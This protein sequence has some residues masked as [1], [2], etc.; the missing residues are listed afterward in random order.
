MPLLADG[1]THSFIG[2]WVSAMLFQGYSPKTISNNVL[3]RIATLYNKAVEEALAE[4]TSVFKDHIKNLNEDGTDA[5][6]AADCPKTFNK[7]QELVRRDYSPAPRKQLAKDIVLFSIYM[8]GMSFSR[9]CR[10]WE[11]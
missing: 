4:P 10:L 6:I 7:L 11:G 5:T 3:K 2:E 9:N 1:F 8:G